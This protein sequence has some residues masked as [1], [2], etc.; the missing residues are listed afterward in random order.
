MFHP[1]VEVALHD[2][3]AGPIVALWNPFSG[4]RPGDRSPLTPEFTAQPTGT[5][6]I[7]PHPLIGAAAAG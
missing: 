7:G 3:G 4:R 1:H 5:R 2:L 6:V